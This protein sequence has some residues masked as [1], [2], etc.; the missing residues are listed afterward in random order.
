MSN[1]KPPEH[2]LKMIINNEVY[3]VGRDP[4][5]CRVYWIRDHGYWVAPY[6]LSISKKT[7]KVNRIN[8]NCKLNGKQKNFAAK[9]TDSEPTVS[10]IIRAVK[11]TQCKHGL[12]LLCYRDAPSNQDT[13][14]IKQLPNN[15]IIAVASVPRYY[16]Y[17]KASR[18]LSHWFEDT[19]ENREK[20]LAE[21]I[22]KKRAVRSEAI[23]KYT[24]TLSQALTFHETLPEGVVV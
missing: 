3:R 13:A 22:E 19:E 11:Y 8:V 23:A 14:R 24:V 2:Y 17:N 15:K 10:A 16:H 21:V 7:K 20:A 1:T 4:Q 18:V 6:G 9:V 12:V 5:G